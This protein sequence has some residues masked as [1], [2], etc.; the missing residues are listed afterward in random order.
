MHEIETVA[1]D[2]ERQ[3]VCELSLF[4]E[5]LDLLGI[6]IVA[7]ATDALDFANLTGTGSSL[8]V[9]EVNLGVGAEVDD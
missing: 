7:L 4:E 6:V 5:V 1:D 3:L 2:N 9:L 8:D